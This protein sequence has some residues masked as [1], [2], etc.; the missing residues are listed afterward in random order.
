LSQQSYRPFGKKILKEKTGAWINPNR[1]QVILCQGAR[2]AGKSVLDE[3][4]A[5][6]LYLQG[7]TILDLLAARNAENLFWAINKNHKE[8]WK[9]KVALDPS[10]QGMPHCQCETSYPITLL[11]PEYMEFDRKKL[12]E[13]NQV[14]LTKTEYVRLCIEKKWIPEWNPNKRPR[15]DEFDKNWQP[16]M[17]LRLLPAPTTTGSNK[18]LIEDIF[19]KA[20]VEARRERR[21]VCMNPMFYPNEYHKYRTMEIIIRC[22]GRMMYTHFRPLTVEEVGKPREKWNRFQRNHH[23]VGV[24]MR[25]FGEVTAAVLKGENQSTMAKKALLDYIR[26]TRHYNISLIG[27]YQRPDDVFS[28]IRDQADIFIIKR[29]PRKLL[30]DAW[31]WMF[32]DIENRREKIIFKY[33][34]QRGTEIA[35]NIVPKIQELGN[36]YAYV[37]YINDKYKLWKIPTPH[38]HHKDR[39][40]HFEVVTGLTWIEKAHGKVNLK[41]VGKIAE[42]NQEDALKDSWEAKMYEVIRGMVRPLAPKKSK[43]WS[44]VFEE[45]AEMVGNGVLEMPATW[46]TPDAMRK[47]FSRKEK[48]MLAPLK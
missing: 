48:K 40:D 45:V 5:E 24:V 26:Q 21:I 12:D 43:K 47:W 32:D 15:H 17:R 8:E 1:P 25:E 28:G 10:L 22:L 41:M 11:I 18:Q 14:Y 37:I 30:G 33:G 2:G 42:K 34:L 27:D 46:S 39:E 38:F 19:M 6:V 4:A 29:S 3:M 36:N 35:D 44:V 9:K 13:F 20:V 31:K 7:W 16:K 23:R